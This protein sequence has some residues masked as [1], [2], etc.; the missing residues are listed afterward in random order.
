MTDLITSQL[1][2]YPASFR[3]RETPEGFSAGYGTTVGLGVE[4][5]TRGAKFI[6]TDAAHLGETYWINR[7]TN[8]TAVW[9][10]EYG[11]E[12]LHDAAGREIDVAYENFMPQRFSYDETTPTTG[13]QTFSGAS[14][15][16]TS[17][18]TDNDD[19]YINT[20]GSVLD[21]VVPSGSE[22]FDWDIEFNVFPGDSGS[23]EGNFVAGLVRASDVAADFL[24]DNGGGPPA[25]YEGCLFWKKDGGTVWNWEYSRQTSQFGTQEVG[26]FDDITW[27]ALRINYTDG[28]LTPYLNGVAGTPHTVIIAPSDYFRVLLGVKAGTG[29]ATKL[30]IDYWKSLMN[31]ITGRFSA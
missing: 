24:G 15:V 1:S 6:K 23:G 16:L 25:D 26:N 18:A 3:G 14:K 29:T 4:R 21:L 7:G 13:A 8:V 11:G 31:F 28:V 27:T 30:T 17:A 10:P 22:R 12:T 20:Q 2:D 19:I 9:S 5:W